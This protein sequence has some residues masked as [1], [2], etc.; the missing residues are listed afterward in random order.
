MR[1]REQGGVEG[2]FGAE[3]EDLVIVRMVD[4]CE[5]TEVLTV[6]LLDD[7]RELLRELL[8]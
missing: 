4:V 7:G 5:N 1:D 3:V 8:T 2:W 6:H